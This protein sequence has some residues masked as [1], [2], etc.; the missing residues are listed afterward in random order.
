MNRG[1]LGTPLL[2]VFSL[3]ALAPLAVFAEESESSELARL[4]PRSLI[5][6]AIVSGTALVAVGDRGHILFAPR[7]EDP[8][9]Q[10][11]GPSRAML[12]S[13]A[14]DQKDG[15]VAVGH[16]STI[17]LSRDR[18]ASW[19]KTPAPEGDDLALFSVH[20]HSPQEGVIVGGYGTMLATN[21]GGATWERI[22][23]VSPETQA[24]EDRHLYDIAELPSGSIVVVGEAGALYQKPEGNTA[25]SARTSPYEG[26]LFG[27]LGCR[28]GTLLIF[29]LRGHLYRSR[30]E[31]RTWE[32]I[33]T[34]STLSIY[35]G[36]ERPSGE[37]VLGGASG[38]MLSAASCSSSFS[39]HSRPDRKAISTLLSLPSGKL[40][41]GGEAGIVDPSLAG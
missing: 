9:K 41:I 2:L 4:A 3:F 10:V 32:S 28:D 22:E 40:L 8:W 17:L 33:A 16:K 14:S 11:S 36:L 12:T 31:G 30:D 39:L 35:T 34:G 26:T 23:L 24:E 25:W 1:F 21:N 5:N 20:F 27:A 6:D 7:E 15:L 18:G 37:V 29:G 19:I 38:L 13:V